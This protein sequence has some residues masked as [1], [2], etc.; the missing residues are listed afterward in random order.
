MQKLKSVTVVIPTY[1][2][3]K[4]ISKCLDSC[5][6]SD[7]PK[8]DLEILVVD[9]IG[10]DNTREIVKEYTQKFPF[11]KL[12]DNPNRYTPFAFNIGIK[13]SSKEIIMIMG[14]HSQYPMDYISKC[15]YYLKKYK[16]DNVGGILK[17]ISREN[18]IIGRSIALVMSHPF[19]VGNSSFRIGSKE[20]KWVDTVFGGCYR[21]EIFD[22]IG[23]FNENLIRGQDR[24]LNARLKQKGGKILLIPEIVCHYYPPDTYKNFVKKTISNG[25]WPFYMNK[26]LQKRAISWR[27][28]VPL[29]F[30]LILFMSLLFSIIYNKFIGYALCSA[31][32]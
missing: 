32:T 20:P 24:E 18:T 22:K 29:F 8:E 30:T 27:N 16:A 10:Q 7:F 14:A 17:T 6:E 31:K 26:F 21:K 28:Y 12:L 15:L 19:G 5:I 4:F 25:F 23:L 3:G 1:N 9:G 2:E 11:I 13:N